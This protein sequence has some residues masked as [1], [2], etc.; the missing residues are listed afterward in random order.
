MNR[1]RAAY[2]ALQQTWP[3]ASSPDPLIDAMQTGDRLGYHPERAPEEL[4]HF[5]DALRKAQSSVQALAPGFAQNLNDTSK[6]ISANSLTPA[7]LEAQKQRRLD[8]LN[9]AEH[10]AAEAGK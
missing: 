9:R 8:A 3:V 6:D 4:A 10:L 7:E 1:L 2:D 5:Q